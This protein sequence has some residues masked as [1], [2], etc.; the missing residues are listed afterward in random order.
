MMSKKLNQLEVTAI[1]GNNISSCLYVSPLAIV[2]AG[3]YAWISLLMVALVM[4]ASCKNSNNSGYAN[5][6]AIVHRSA[7][8]SSEHSGKK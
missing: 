3:Q 1:C 7:S 5:Q 6:D 8:D 2:Y 4:F